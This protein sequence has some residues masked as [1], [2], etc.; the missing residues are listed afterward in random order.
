M[1][2][3]LIR[4]RVIEKW[5]ASFSPRTI[6]SLPPA[7]LCMGTR[8]TARDESDHMNTNSEGSERTAVDFVLFGLGFFFFVLAVAGIILN[9]IPLTITAGL[10]SGIGWLGLYFRQ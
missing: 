5:V 6:F 10:V 1:G 7:V 2:Q 4:R 8:Q 9:S 3:T